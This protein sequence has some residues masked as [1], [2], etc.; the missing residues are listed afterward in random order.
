MRSRVA[1]TQTGARSGRRRAKLSMNPGSEATG[2]A[3]Q[4][5]VAGRCPKLPLDAEV[6]NQ[7]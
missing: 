7:S 3:S 5:G 4:R 1:F 2:H 6:R